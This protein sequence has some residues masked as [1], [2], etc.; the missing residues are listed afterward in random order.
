[1]AKQNF[2]MYTPRDK[3][4]KRPRIHTK[5]INKNKPKTKQKYR[6]QGK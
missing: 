5:S 4:K 3:H 6:G 2:S 1:M